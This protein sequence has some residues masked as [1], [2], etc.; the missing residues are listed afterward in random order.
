MPLCEDGSFKTVKILG[1]EYYGKKL[2][3][4]IEE[5][6]RKGDYSLNQTEKQKGLDMMFFMW[7]HPDSPLFGKK[8]MATFERYFIEDKETHYEEK[9]PYYSL[10]DDENV[11]NSVLKEFGLDP[12]NGQV[13]CFAF[14]E[15]STVPPQCGHV[16]LTSFIQSYLP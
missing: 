5:Y 7:E 4:F 15:S 8:K 13:A 14:F 9:N 2:Y 12:Q 16:I 3:D 11:V 1:K 10:F 6:A